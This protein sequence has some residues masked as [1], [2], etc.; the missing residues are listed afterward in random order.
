[1]L[2]LPNKKLIFLHIPK[3]GGTSINKLIQDRENRH[4]IFGKPNP[5]DK[6]WGYILN[7]VGN[8]DTKH[9]TFKEINA[10]LIFR[11]IRVQGWSFVCV[12]RNPYERILS[13]HRYLRKYKPRK[14]I[15]FPK[16]VNKFISDFIPNHP[17]GFSLRS[18]KKQSSFIEGINSINLKVLK[19]ESLNQDWLKL[20]SNYNDQ[21]CLPRSNSTQSKNINIARNILSDDSIKI[22]NKFYSDDFKRFG[23][24]KYV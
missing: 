13:L 20:L 12:V 17:E 2:V 7:Y 5:T 3:T 16:D 1:M 18:L 4:R 9:L 23:Y 8:F 21:I 6:F 19:T 15:K 22:V 11:L 10:K 14:D 24:M